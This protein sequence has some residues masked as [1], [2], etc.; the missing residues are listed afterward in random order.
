MY[1]FDDFIATKKLL[2]VIFLPGGVME[3]VRRLGVL[4]R[5]R[6]TAK[7]GARTRDVGRG[8]PVARRTAGCRRDAANDVVRNPSDTAARTSKPTM[9][10]FI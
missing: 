4:F 7:D 8:P 3:G 10:M 2:L 9:T 1:F 5:R 6:R